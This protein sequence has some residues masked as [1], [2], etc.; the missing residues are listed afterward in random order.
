[1]GRLWAADLDPDRGFFELGATSMTATRAHQLIC[2]ELGVEFPLAEIFRHPTV[3]KLAA[4]FE[5]R[6]HGTAAVGVVPVR[7]VSRPVEDEPIAIIGMACRLPGA[8]D[9][10]AF[11]DNLRGGVESIRRFSA[12]ELRQA[13]SARAA[14]RSGL[15][16]RE[17]LG[18]G[19]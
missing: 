14:G 9:V 10:G 1:M 7:A 19:R 11:W 4:F 18:G 2:A 5:R 3:N 13:G 6:S 17:G 12:E 15:R 8:A 16:A